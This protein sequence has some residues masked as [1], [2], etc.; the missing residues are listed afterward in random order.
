MK[1]FSIDIWNVITTY[2]VE[3]EMKYME[4]ARWELQDLAK[5]EKAWVS[6]WRTYTLSG[7]KKTRKGKTE[8]GENGGIGGGGA[9]ETNIPAER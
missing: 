6:W 7:I 4:R 1:I 2:W 8:G 9:G 5:D 3:E